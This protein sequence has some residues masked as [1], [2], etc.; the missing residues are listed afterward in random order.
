M[1][2]GPESDD[3][4]QLAKGLI[5]RGEAIVLCDG[6]PGCS[7]VHNGRCPI[8]D[9]VDAVVVMPV[10][11]LASREIA[12]GLTL[13]ARGAHCAIALEPSIIHVSSGSGRLRSLDPGVVDSTINRLASGRG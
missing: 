2:V 7:M 9:T 10:T 5:D 13:C 11:G 6:P 4:T 3:R 1:L 12:A 8:V